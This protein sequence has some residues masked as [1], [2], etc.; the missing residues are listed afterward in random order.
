MNHS[1]EQDLC[2]QSCNISIS[3]SADST[4][5]FT[6]LQL[7]LNSLRSLGPHVFLVFSAVYE[8]TV[9]R[10]ATHRIAICWR[11]KYCRLCALRIIDLEV[12]L[13]I[14]LLSPFSV[15]VCYLHN[16]WN[17]VTGPNPNVKC[18][19]VISRQWL[20]QTFLWKHP[21]NHTIIII[22]RIRSPILKRK[23]HSDVLTLVLATVP[24]I[25]QLKDT[26]CCPVLTILFF[27]YP[28]SC[29]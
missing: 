7:F 20:W 2:L 11:E 9:R 8:P 23:S 3:F 26:V 16:M 18:E 6:V 10:G 29:W 15:S 28:I 19:S 12:S 17:F 4:Q 21:Y 22:I 1:Q 25:V 5:L 14:R 13:P 24:W 27:L